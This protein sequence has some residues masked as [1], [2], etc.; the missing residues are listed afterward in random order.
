[1]G[2][3]KTESAKVWKV[4]GIKTKPELLMC[5]L[6]ISVLKLEEL[7]GRS[8]SNKIINILSDP[9]FDFNLLKTKI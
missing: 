3:E 8:L 5:S 7:A 9:A 1:M 6:A 4:N 2:D